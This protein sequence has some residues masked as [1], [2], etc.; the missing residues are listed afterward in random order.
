LDIQTSSASHAL[1]LLM[2]S[3]IIVVYLLVLLSVIMIKCKK[4]TS[5]K[6]VRPNA[7]NALGSTQINVPNAP[8][9]LLSLIP[10]AP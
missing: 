8:L 6:P 3:K 1:T 10:P 5:V 4:S 2:S 7:S 9:V